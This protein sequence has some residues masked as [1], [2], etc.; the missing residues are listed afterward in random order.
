MLNFK[1]KLKGLN[2]EMED[3]TGCLLV[4]QCGCLLYNSY[5][6]S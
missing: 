6:F 2:K 1:A 3:G 4:I 5:N